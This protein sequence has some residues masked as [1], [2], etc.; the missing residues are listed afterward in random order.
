MLARLING[1]I[2]PSLLFLG[3]GERLE[4]ETFYKNGDMSKS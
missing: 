3:T 2:K 1:L 4:R